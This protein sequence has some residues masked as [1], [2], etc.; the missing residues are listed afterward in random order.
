[1]AA[2]LNQ[3]YERLNGVRPYHP[4]SANTF[5]DWAMEAGDI[6]TVSRDGTSYQSPVHASRMT[7]R[8]KQQIS[9]NSEGKKERDAIS[10]ISQRKYGRGGGGIRSNRYLYWEMSS[11]DGLLHAAISATEKE[12]QSDYTQKIEETNTTLNT[13]ITQNAQ[14]ITLEAN[15]AK[16]SERSL[17]SRI[18]VE[19][20]KISQIVEAVGTDG[21]VTA[22]SIV[23]AI[24]RAGESEAHIDA[25]KVYIGNS[26]S[27]T[28]INGKL[29]V[30]DLSS[31]ISS[32]AYVATQ[33]L[34][35]KRFSLYESP[36]ESTTAVNL[37]ST[38]LRTAALTRN[39]NTYYLHLYAI[40]GTECV[41]T[42]DNALSFSRAT[43]LAG[44]WS[45][46]T[47]TVNASPQ[48]NTISAGLF[49]LRNEDVSWNGN[50]ATITLYANQNG[51]ETR[52]NTGK[53]LT[54]D[55][56]A[57]YQAGFDAGDG[58]Y[59]RYSMAKAYNTND[60]IYY[61]KFYNSSGTALTSESYYWYG[62]KQNWNGGNANANLY[63]KI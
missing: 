6:V 37:A 7:W 51:G 36:A 45:G 27:T 39:G 14:T 55:A 38:A 57:I 24:N 42:R 3:I 32:L 9:I 47:F 49:D 21:Q 34:S 30:A 54:V 44:V 60:T 46:G 61:G 2:N 19:A 15:R 18:T 26:K 40:D 16:E 52:Y 13:K 4:I 29:N 28:V 22:A 17:S 53:T 8:G 41:S 33:S 56:S 31:E 12:L 43:T 1:M 35:A 20:D 63:R 25:N 50:I 10:K 62:S 59:T 58:Q 11:D 23:L 48:G 5:A